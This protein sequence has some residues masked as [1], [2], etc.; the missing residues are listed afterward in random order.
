MFADTSTIDSQTSELTLSDVRDRR[1]E[2]I[3]YGFDTSDTTLIEALPVSGKSY[4]IIK[5]ASETAKQLTVFA[6]RHDLVAEFERRCERFGLTY[7]RLP[8]FY[9]DC[10]SFRENDDEEYEPVDAAAKRLNRRY[11][12]GFPGDRLHSRLTGLPCQSGG[13]CP[14]ISKRDFDPDEYDVLLG[15]Y[16]HAHREEWIEDRYVAFDEFPSDDYLTT[17]DD[18]IAPVVSAYVEDEDNDLPFTD[19]FDLLARRSDTAVQDTIEGWKDSLSSW[20]SN[21]Q[22]A[23]NSKSSLAHA[24]APVATLALIEMEPL[25][26]DWKYADLGHD[27]VAVR[28]PKTAEWTFL[29]PPDLSSAKSVVGLDG[30]P[31][32]SLWEIVLGEEIQ[33]VSLLGDEER[34]TYLE[35]VLGYRFVQTTGSWKAIQS[36]EGA[37]PPKDLAFIEGVKQEEEQSP[38]IISSQRAIQQ[39][40]SNGLSELTDTHEHYS[41]LK[42]MNEFGG[43]RS[44]IVLGN[45][46][47]GDDEIEKWSAL[48][49]ESAQRK[50]IG[51]EI[52]TGPDTDY[53]VF[54]NK[55]MHTFLHD[56]VLQAAMRFGREEAEEGRGATVYIHT[57]AIPAWLPVDRN[58]VSIQPWLTEGEVEHGM[59]QTIDAIHSLKEWRQS[60]WKATSLYELTKISDKQVRSCLEGLA[61]DDFIKCLGKQG[62]GNA[63]HYT[64][65]KLETAGS[66]GNVTF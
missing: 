28:N 23:R 65:I 51:G 62:Q 24:L 57:S 49:G 16:R 40:Q 33:T 27:R 25:D 3:H 61:E 1:D 50:E 37:A 14:F 55:V 2:L 38:A 11:Q 46:H 7:S 32:G 44:G 10:A 30:T 63:L 56:E 18:G 20:S 12:Q 9:R 42:G 53:G 6:P 26:N 64:N 5:W 43:E 19:Y 59:K 8:S 13:A 15:T 21:Y 35:D 22:H 31:N 39:Y 29:L 58:I 45:P 4:G 41:N 47:P 36:G 48:A 66:F 52:T 34:E 54:G 60:E 17:F